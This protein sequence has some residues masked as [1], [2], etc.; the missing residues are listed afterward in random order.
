MA[1]LPL[2]ANHLITGSAANLTAQAIIPVLLGSGFVDEPW[3][4]LHYRR[5]ALPSCPLPMSDLKP[6]L[7]NA[8]PLP[9]LCWIN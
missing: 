7:A 1:A 8:A 2:L 6:Y 3:R 5:Q 9:T 4:T